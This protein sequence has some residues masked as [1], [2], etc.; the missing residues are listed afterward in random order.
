MIRF[1][2]DVEACGQKA[3]DVVDMSNTSAGLLVATGRAALAEPPLKPSEQTGPPRVDRAA[4][5]YLTK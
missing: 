4:K 3:G 2:V 5:G 1:L